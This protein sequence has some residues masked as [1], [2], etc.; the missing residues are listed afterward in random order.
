MKKLLVAAAIILGTY[1]ASAQSKIGYINSDELMGD[2]PEAA[3]ADAELKQFQTDLGKQGQDLMNDLNTKDSLFVKD[4]TSFSPSIKEIKRNELIKLY[5]RVQ[6][7]QNEAQELYQAEAQK[8]IVP[9]RN[10]ALDAIKAVAKENGY[11]YV[12]D[13][14]QGSLLIAPPGDDLLPLVK[15]K[16][17]ITASVPVKKN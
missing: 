13:N 2:M 10:K 8:K 4:S 7:W 9:I 11:G 14:A 1:S 6:G 15:K 5:Q 16:L 17:G 3:K 12:F